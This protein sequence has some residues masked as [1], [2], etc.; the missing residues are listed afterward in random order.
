MFFTLVSSGTSKGPNIIDNDQKNSRRLPCPG[1]LDQIKNGNCLNAEKWDFQMT[2]NGCGK[3]P[4]LNPTE[5]VFKSSK[6]NQEVRAA[7]VKF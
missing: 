5:H 6:S 4:D 2:C 1:A 7:P 3:S